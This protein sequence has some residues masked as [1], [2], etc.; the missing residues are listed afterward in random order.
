MS[1][2]SLA[3]VVVLAAFSVLTLLALREV[4][5]IGIVT[6]Q[7]G[8]WGQ[9]QVLVDLVIL[10]LLSCF[11]MAG[12]APRHGLSPWPFIAMTLVAGSFGPLIYLLVRELRTGSRN[13]TVR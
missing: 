10:A 7:F 2:R 5:Y 12:D 3:L 4:G 6:G 8:H 11:W 9:V 1:G 13:A